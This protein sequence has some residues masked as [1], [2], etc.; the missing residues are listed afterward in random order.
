MIRPRGLVHG[1][2]CTDL[3]HPDQSIEQSVE[4]GYILQGR[5][6][7]ILVISEGGPTTDPRGHRDKEH[8]G[9]GAYR[10]MRALRS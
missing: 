3:L 2:Q 6:K 4:D 1:Y 8:M 10:Q 5:H 9:L 7:Y